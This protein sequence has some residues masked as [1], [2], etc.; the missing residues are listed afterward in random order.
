M[1]LNAF[2]YSVLKNRFQAEYKPV[3]ET[4]RQYGLIKE[5]RSQLNRRSRAHSAA[6]PEYLAN[7]YY[8]E[9]FSLLKNNLFDPRAID[10]QRATDFLLEAPQATPLFFSSTSRSSVTRTVQALLWLYRGYERL[11]QRERLLDFDD[12]KLRSYALLHKHADVLGSLQGRLDEVIVDEFQDINRLDFMLIKAIAKTAVLVVTGDDDQA[13]YGFRGCTPE[14]IIDLE[15][16]LGRK[17]ES[18][19][20]QINY[21]C[22]PIIVEHADRLIRHNTW[23]IPKSPRAH[24]DVPAQVHVVS[25]ISAGLEA[26]SIVSLIERVRSKDSALRYSDF[27]VLYRTNAQ[28]L[29]L[30]VEFILSKIPYYVRKE[31]NVLHN[32]GL[33]KLLSI[34]RTKLALNQGREPPV[35]DSARTVCSFFRYVEPKTAGRLR[36]ALRQEGDLL[37]TVYSGRLDRFL[38]ERGRELLPVAMRELMGTRSLLDTLDVVARRFYGVYGMIGSL[39]EAIDNRVPLGE[40]YEIAEGFRGNIKQFVDMLDSAMEQA[41]A[42]NA[43]HDHRAGVPLLT[44][45]RAKGLQWHT[46]ILT[47]CNEGLI[48]HEKAPVE[49]ERRLFYVA[50]TRASANLVLSY[51]RSACACQVEP[52]RFLYEAGLLTKPERRRRESTRRASRPAKR[53]GAA[54][55]RAPRSA[56]YAGSSRSRVFHRPDCSSVEAIEA[57]RLVR[58]AT[59]EE[60]IQAGKKPCAR[61]AP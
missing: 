5:L 12:Q 26:K 32:E 33:E 53:A 50:I 13:I 20:L 37:E 22:P 27:A 2:G 36:A 29:P 7:R 11:L 23:R 44:Y 9:F 16:H 38:P 52:S 30:Q 57:G 55:K 19:E 43:G 56:A 59:R 6:L 15:D 31:D 60:A 42:S 28:S 18:H 51:V 45:F 39:E 58:F 34:L 40:I 48:P 10:E 17:F 46:V 4:R 21:R 1:T 24:H 47:T 25:S 61:C 54:G 41:R 35:E 49:E 3:I 8:L 14:F